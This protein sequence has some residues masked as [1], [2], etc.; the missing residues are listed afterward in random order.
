VARREGVWLIE[1]RWV[2]GNDRE[3]G[4]ILDRGPYP[5]RAE[6][7]SVAAFM[8]SQ[9]GGGHLYRPRLYRAKVYLPAPPPKRK[10]KR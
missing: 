4:P 8:A 6:A 1:G 5:T 3:W 10:P 9:S 2:E 7:L